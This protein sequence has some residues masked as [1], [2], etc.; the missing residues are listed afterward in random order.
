V[1]NLVNVAQQS[2]DSAFG[3]GRG[4]ILIAGQMDLSLESTVDSRPARDVVRH[5]FDR[6]TIHGI[7]LLPTWTAV[8]LC[9]LIGAFIAPSSLLEDSVPLTAFIVHSV[10]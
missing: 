1:T 10:R 8:P 5:A 6:R 7:G 4:M 3:A 9:L 2:T